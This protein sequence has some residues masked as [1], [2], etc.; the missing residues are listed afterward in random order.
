M[1]ETYPRYIHKLSKILATAK[2]ET[3]EAYL[4]TRTALTLASLLG[5]GTDAWKAHRELYEV[6]NGVKKGA[7][8][9]RAEY[10]VKAVDESLGFASGRFFVQR[11]FAGNSRDQAFGLISS[12]DTLKSEFVMLNRFASLCRCH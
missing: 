1:I 12:E 10:C 8:G 11:E 9:D 4:I 7:V 5:P 6:L 2:A 3:V